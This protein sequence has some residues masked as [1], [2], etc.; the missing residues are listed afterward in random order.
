[1]SFAQELRAIYNPDDPETV[2]SVRN[3]AIRAAESYR[4]G[5]G[6]KYLK[7]VGDDF[8]AL[9]LLHKALDDM[10]PEDYLSPPPT[11]L[12]REQ[13]QYRYGYREGT[14]AF[15]AAIGSL[16][17]SGIR[18][19]LE[20]SMHELIDPNNDR[21]ETRFKELAVDTVERQLSDNGL[22]MLINSEVE[23]EFPALR[24]IR[25][26][27]TTNAALPNEW[28]VDGYQVGLIISEGATGM[29]ALEYEY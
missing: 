24:L 12:T 19:E 16:V 22:A 25:N 23:R 6:P 15:T 1:M 8:P 9:G 26:T 5:I 17:V 3:A 11:R 29:I 28:H 14:G 13:R 27:L 21:T 18:P 7:S 10:Y 20:R 4:L 2:T